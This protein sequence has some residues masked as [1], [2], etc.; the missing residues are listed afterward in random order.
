MN[1]LV[2]PLLKLFRLLE[3]DKSEPSVDG[4]W[5]ILVILNYFEFSNLFTYISYSMYK[6]VWIKCKSMLEV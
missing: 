1:L 3:N 4:L 2:S 5:N 6:V